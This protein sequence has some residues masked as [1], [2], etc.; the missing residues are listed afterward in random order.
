MSFLTNEV[1]GLG[2]IHLWRSHGE[3]RGSGGRMWTGEGVHRSSP[4]WTSTQKI[5]IRV[6][7]C[8]TVFF[9]CKKVG[10]FFTKISSLDRKKVEIFLWF[11]L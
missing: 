8:H 11:K 10:I 7:W 2:P 3:G 4:M 1:K 9:S 6:H 5:K